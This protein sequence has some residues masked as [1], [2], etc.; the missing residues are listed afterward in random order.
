LAVVFC[1]GKPF[2]KN[3]FH[4]FGMLIFSIIGFIYAEYIVF[5]VDYFSRKWIYISAY[6][7]DPFVSYYILNEE[8][9]NTFDIPFK[10]YIMGI[11]V[12]N[13]FVCFI[14]EKIIV[15]NCYKCWRRRKMNKLREELRLN[16]ENEATLNLINNVKNYIR[17]QQKSKKV[18]LEI[19]KEEPEIEMEIK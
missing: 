2:K 10:Y 12:V 4:N 11:I 16:G 14:I 9:K 7:D 15:P 17:E 3:I 8:Q 5:Y 6:P 13:F 1:T 18:D 19:K